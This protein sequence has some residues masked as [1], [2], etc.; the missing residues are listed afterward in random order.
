MELV[1][2]RIIR[3]DL[4]LFGLIL[5]VFSLPFSTLINSASIIFISLLWL[6]DKDI[7][8]RLKKVFTNYITYILIF[9]FIVCLL[10]MLYTSN[11]KAGV[12]FLTKSFSLILLPIILGSYAYSNKILQTILFT[13]ILAIFC[14]ITFSIVKVFYLDYTLI[15]EFSLYNTYREFLIQPLNIHPTYWS[16]YIIFSIY[17]IIYIIINNKWHKSYLGVIGLIL[18]FYFVGFSLLLSARMPLI[19]FFFCILTTAIFYAF[20]FKKYF[21]II[22]ALAFISAVLYYIFTNPMF[23]QRIL[24]IKETA[25]K[26]PVSIYHNSINIRVGIFTCTL[27]EIK[28]AWFLGTGTGDMQDTLNQCYQNSGYSDVLFKLSYNTHST[29]FDAILRLGILGILS[30]L[31]LFYFSFKMAIKSGNILYLNFIITISITC[32]TESILNSQKGIVFFALFNSLFICY[33]H[34]KLNKIDH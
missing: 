18:V 13:F 12:G 5:I 4:H 9:Y 15:S 28:E 20:K 8:I 1:S 26:P 30:L 14:S 32:L 21:V 10:G 11:Q 34:S 24:E 27:K 29:Y 19:S 2:K 17:S 7:I 16:I 3:Q 31:I 22:L 23:N 6:L 33:T 25:L